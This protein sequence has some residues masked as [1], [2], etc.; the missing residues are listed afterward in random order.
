MDYQ[1]A[2]V[3][4]RGALDCQVCVLEEWHDDTVK[5]FADSANPCG[6]DNGWHIRRAGD[7]ALKGDAERACCAQRAGFV[8]LALHA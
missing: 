5:A 4:R 7:P 1:G 6:T 2:A 3:I 8:H